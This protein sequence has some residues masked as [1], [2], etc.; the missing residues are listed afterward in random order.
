MINP[1][2]TRAVCRST[3]KVQNQHSHY[4]RIAP[5]RLRCS[6]GQQGLKPA[7]SC[8][9]QQVPLRAD[10]AIWVYSSEACKGALVVI[11]TC[12]NEGLLSPCLPRFQR[13]AIQGGV[14]PLALT[15]GPTSWLPDYLGLRSLRLPVPNQAARE[16]VTEPHPS[17]SGQD[18]GNGRSATTGPQGL[19]GPFF[20]DQGY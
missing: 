4:G 19:R 7:V 13:S 10:R 20:R 9:V 1:E 11:D 2:A 5:K 3:E 16:S 14:S 17:E 15:F 6:I 8:A 18:E 12:R